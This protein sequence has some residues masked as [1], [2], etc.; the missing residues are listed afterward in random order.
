MGEPVEGGKKKKKKKKLQ[1]CRTR[2]HAYPTR[3]CKT[4]GSNL[5]LGSSKRC[6]FPFFYIRVDPCA[7]FEGQE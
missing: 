4:F 3:M 6:N 5:L 2:T 7:F 1:K